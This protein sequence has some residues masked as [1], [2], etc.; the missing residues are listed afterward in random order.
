MYKTSPPLRGTRC[1][2]IHIV[3]WVIT[4]AVLVF[5]PSEGLADAFSQGS[6]PR[7]TGMMDTAR[8]KAILAPLCLH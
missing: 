1:I 7:D 5:I 4:K 3:R 6:R 2:Y 8:F